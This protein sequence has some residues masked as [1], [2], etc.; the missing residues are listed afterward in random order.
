MQF[1]L[2]RVLEAQVVE[3]NESTP[4][5]RVQNLDREPKSIPSMDIA[6]DNINVFRLEGAC[7]G[8]I[9]YLRCLFCLLIVLLPDL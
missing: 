6:D 1:L 4:T 8:I 5:F 9:R 2:G 3:D 7:I